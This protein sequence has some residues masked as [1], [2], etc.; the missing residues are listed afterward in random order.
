MKRRSTRTIRWAATGITLALALGGLVVA[1]SAS[2]ADV[3]FP[4][5]RPGQPIAPVID[6]NFPDLHLHPGDSDHAIDPPRNR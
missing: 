2:A 1:A 4:Q 5:A 3:A 6:A